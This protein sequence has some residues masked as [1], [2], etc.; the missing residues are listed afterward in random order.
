M[1]KIEYSNLWLFLFNG[2]CIS[3]I[4]NKKRTLKIISMQFLASKTG[5][6]RIN[7]RK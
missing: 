3:I 5:T 7:E 2:K 1:D 4:I 6:F